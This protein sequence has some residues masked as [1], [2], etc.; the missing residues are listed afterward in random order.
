MADAPDQQGRNV[1]A[2]LARVIPAALLGGVLCALL[3]GYLSSRQPDRYEAS[4]IV[5]L[6]QEN[7]DPALV[8]GTGQDEGEGI[9]TDA[10]AIARQGVLQRVADQVALDVDD[11]RDAVTVA[12]IGETNA[13]RVQVAASEAQLAARIAN[14]VAD[15]FIEIRRQSV[16]DRARR[17]RRVLRSRL[18]ALNRTSRASLPGVQLR[19]RIQQ[20][21]VL[22][23]LGGLAPLV[24]ER[25]RA[26]ETRVSPRPRRDALLGGLFGVLIGGGLGVLW[27]GAD[28]RVRDAGLTDVLRAPVLATVK[29][30]RRSDVDLARRNVDSWRLLHLSLRHLH[31]DR[32]LRS[33]AITEPRSRFGRTGTSLGLAAAAAAAGERVLLVT[34]SHTGL[35]APANGNRP[36]GDLAAV[37]ERRAPVE[38]SVRR[39]QLETF[40]PESAFDVLTTAGEDQAAPA[41]L[42]RFGEVIRACASTYD[43]VVVDVPSLLDQADAIALLS[44]TDGT[45]VTVLR[46]ID[47]DTARALAER[48]DALA[49]PRLGLVTR[50]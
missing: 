37:L 7:L 30:P 28:R 39:V 36:S 25:A 12:Q 23:R 6:R 35:G 40:G 13:A 8:S 32:P 27:A 9:A 1:G 45:V 26:P 10:L 33:V 29:S 20:L 41:T 5:L 46:S 2:L 34:L 50:S 49:V 22:E 4:S 21:E 42:S 16:R 11:V 44:P 14:L 24:L 47:R 15:T 3:A 17:A 18:N 31:R 19:E 48:L 43:L 38:E